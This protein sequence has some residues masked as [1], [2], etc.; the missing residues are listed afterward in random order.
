[1]KPKELTKIGLTKAQSTIYV[2]LLELGP[3]SVGNILKEI[4]MSRISCYDTL[5]RLISKGLVSFVNTKKVDY[6]KQ[7]TL[8]N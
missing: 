4:D 5:N 3:S 7:Q 6:I 2:K 1:M 8:K